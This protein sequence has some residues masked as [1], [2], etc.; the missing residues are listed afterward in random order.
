M[1][2]VLLETLVQIESNTQVQIESNTQVY[3]K[4]TGHLILV[5]DNKDQW[6]KNRNHY[7]PHYAQY[8]SCPG[9]IESGEDI[10][11][12]QVDEEEGEGGKPM[13]VF[14]TRKVEVIIIFF[15]KCAGS[16][17]DVQNWGVILHVDMESLDHSYFQVC[18]EK[19]E[20]RYDIRYTK[21]EQKIWKA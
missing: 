12:R 16:A 21:T 20:V 7:S 13:F 11:G 9:P 4:E 10:Q 14:L 2:Y 1:T 8:P 17:S 15:D 3:Q 5:P 6:P 18:S 19:N